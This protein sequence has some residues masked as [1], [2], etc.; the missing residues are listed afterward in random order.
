MET[1][2]FIRSVYEATGKPYNW[3]FNE[4]VLD[5]GEPDYEV[6]YVVADDT[7]GTCSTQIHVSQVQEITDVSGL[8]KM[9]IHFEVH[10]K[11]GTADSEKAWIENKY[12]E[13]IIPN[14]DKRTVDFVLFDPGREI[15]KKY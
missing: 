14:P 15:V 3:F 2:D 5:G 12:E 10:Y 4:W 11:D 13:V 1:A 9:P 6:S 8:F 7:N